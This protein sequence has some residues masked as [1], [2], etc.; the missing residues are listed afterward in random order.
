ME[1]RPEYRL[2]EAAGHTSNFAASAVCAG[3][4]IML[5]S[6]ALD[7]V[8]DSGWLKMTWCA[9]MPYRHPFVKMI[10][11]YFRSVLKQRAGAPRSNL[12]SISLIRKRWRGYILMAASRFTP[13]IRSQ[14]SKPRSSISTARNIGPVSILFEIPIILGKMQLIYNIAS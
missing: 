4:D 5:N 12:E 1:A 7:D 14:R 13:P 6:F 11:A 8:R 3:S 9:L 10:L 2:S